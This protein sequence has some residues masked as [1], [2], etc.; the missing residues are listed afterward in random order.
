MRIEVHGELMPCFV[1]VGRMLEALTY[2]GRTNR[3]PLPNP[4]LPRS[5]T[6]GT[7]VPDSFKSRVTIS[8]HGHRRAQEE[9]IDN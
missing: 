4:D 8:G 5:R 6:S 3:G 1:G 9:R 7:H 2:E